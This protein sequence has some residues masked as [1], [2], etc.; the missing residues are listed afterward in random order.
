[1]IRKFV[2]GNESNKV[3]AAA[4][5]IIYNVESLKHYFQVW[6]ANSRRLTSQIKAIRVQ[7]AFNLLR[8][9]QRDNALAI[10]AASK[11]QKK[12]RSI[13]RYLLLLF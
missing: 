11:E 9:L 5:L 10:F 8:E 6:A 2:E 13:L 4:R 7:K 1:M 12:K 3:K